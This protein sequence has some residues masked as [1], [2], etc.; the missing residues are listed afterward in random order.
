MTALAFVPL[1]QP[2]LAI[3]PLPQTVPDPGRFAA[4]VFTSANGVAAFA[5]LT[6]D[7]SRPVFTV[8][9][10]TAAAARTAGFARVQSAR[11]D[12]NQLAA[13]LVAQGTAV[14]PLLVP[15]ALEPAG[16]L[17][18]LLAGRIEATALPVYEAIGTGAA[19]PETFD[20][21]LVHS[22]RA[23]RALSA[24]GPF[25]G[26]RVAVLSAAVA[27]PLATRTDLDIRIAA[28]PDETALFATLGNPARRV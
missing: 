1:V 18:A 26:Q 11:G 15:G 25:T 9:D 22:A 4:L 12:L 7:R 17:P 14:G 10:A 21:A 16:D 19:A 28:T 20:A 24:L 13:F 8:G 5:S 23:A 3:R 6:S 27:A 2:L